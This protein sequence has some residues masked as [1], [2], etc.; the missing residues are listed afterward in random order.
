MNKRSSFFV[1]DEEKSFMLLNSGVI[2]F[3]TSFFFSDE[4]T[5]Q[6]RWF[7]SFHLR[8]HTSLFCRI[9]CDKGKK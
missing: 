7:V 8:K 9:E 2:W 4:E 5:E 1:N 6:A 3:K